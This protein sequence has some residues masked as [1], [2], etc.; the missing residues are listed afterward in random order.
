MIET[1]VDNFSRTLLDLTDIDQ[2]SS[3]RINRAGKNKIGS[4]VAPGSMRPLSSGPNAT[5]FSAMRPTRKN[6]GAR[7]KFEALLTS[8]A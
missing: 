4:V 5:M 8:E 1:L 3:D 2:H 6:N 7:R